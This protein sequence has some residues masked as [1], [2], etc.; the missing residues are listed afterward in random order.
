MFEIVNRT[1]WEARL[2]HELQP[3]SKNNVINGK[4]EG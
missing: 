1:Y 3:D 2:S 4:I